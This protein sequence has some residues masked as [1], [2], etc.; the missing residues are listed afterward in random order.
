MG[1]MSIKDSGERESMSTGS[2]RDIQ[3]G[4][5]R[6]DL[7]PA[8]T[9]TKLALHYGN[10]AVKYGDRNWTKGQPITRMLASLKRHIQKWELGCTDEP[11]MIAMIWNAIAIDYT[12][13][14]IKHGFLPPELDDRPPE[15]REGNKWGAAIA[16]MIER[17]IEEQNKNIKNE[18]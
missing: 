4:K 10:G 13:D 16:E 1:D 6:P 18:V 15:M 9:M 17:N 8:T 12:L 14:A 7:I 11:H 5:P 3:I 2:V